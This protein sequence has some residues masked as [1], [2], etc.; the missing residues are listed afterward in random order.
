MVSGCFWSFSSKPL[1]FFC[2]FLLFKLS[3]LFKNCQ[4]KFLFRQ[5]IGPFLG[6]FW[7]K[8]WPFLLKNLVFEHFLLNHTSDLCKSLPE[9]GDSCFE[10]F[11]SSVVSRKI[12]ILAVLVTF[13]KKIHY[14][15]WQNGAFDRFWPFFAY[16]LMFYGHVLFSDF[17]HEFRSPYHFDDHYKIFG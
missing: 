7:F 9:T 10:S 12:L 5:K 13:G 2:Y 17:M 4:W 14:L 3:S 8:N 6:P 1:M 16:F 11:N 15:W